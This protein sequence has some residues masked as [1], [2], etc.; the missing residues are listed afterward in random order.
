MADTAPP[1]TILSK[2]AVPV[3]ATQHFVVEL[4]NPF[5][6]TKSGKTELDEIF[7]RAQAR[8]DIRD[9][10]VPMFVETMEMEPQLIVE[11]G[12]RTGESTFVF[13]RVARLCGA[14]LVSVDIDDC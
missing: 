8:T 4:I 14:R 2:I 10:L 12:V 9:H 11:L 5:P 13:E 7:Q 3:L 6:F 1:P